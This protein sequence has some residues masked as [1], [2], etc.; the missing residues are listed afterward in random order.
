MEVATKRKTKIT[1]QIRWNRLASDDPERAQWYFAVVNRPDR[2]ST[3]LGRI[4][5]SLE[6]VEI[7]SQIEG[8]VRGENDLHYKL[9]VLKSRKGK[10]DWTEIYKS[11]TTGEIVHDEQLRPRTKELNGLENYVA[12]LLG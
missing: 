11:E 8:K 5:A 9:V 10:I 3:Y 6:N 12:R 4:Y 2:V 1:P 7:E